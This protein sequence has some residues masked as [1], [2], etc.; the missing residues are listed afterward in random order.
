MQLE[1]IAEN[2]RELK[3]LVEDIE[4]QPLEDSEDAR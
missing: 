4:N 1:D 2:A 3:Y